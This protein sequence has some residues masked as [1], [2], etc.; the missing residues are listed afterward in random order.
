M[1]GA[2]WQSPFPP[3]APVRW[4]HDLPDDSRWRPP[5]GEAARAEIDPRVAIEPP[6]APPPAP[7]RL[8]KAVADPRALLTARGGPT[9]DPP[10][11]RPAA[12]PSTRSAP[13]TRC[14]SGAHVGASPR[15]LTHSRD[16]VQEEAD[17]NVR[18]LF[19][20][21]SFK[22][23]AVIQSTH[24]HIFRALPIGALENVS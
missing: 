16:T 10:C 15:R 13:R 2:G 20:P 9:L 18:L 23:S 24:F 11:V 1:D 6:P 19:W 12:P 21:T 4:V 14:H 8:A 7:P 17:V 5:P 3:F 22:V